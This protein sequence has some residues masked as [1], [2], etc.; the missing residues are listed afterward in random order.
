MQPNLAALS[1]PVHVYTN[2][3]F[4]EVCTNLA[5]QPK[6]CR[7]MACNHSLT[8]V[9]GSSQSDVFQWEFQ[10]R[11]SPLVPDV[12]AASKRCNA[13]VAPSA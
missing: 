12:K 7:V 10:S 5:C 4:Q 13:L 1:A 6:I 8:V 9:E 2:V 11:L 3:L